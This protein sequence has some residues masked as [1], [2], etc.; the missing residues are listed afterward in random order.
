MTAADTVRCDMCWQ[1]V[2]SDDGHTWE[3]VRAF[4]LVLCPDC[5]RRLQAGAW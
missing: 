2:R 4:L 1:R 3:T 5:A